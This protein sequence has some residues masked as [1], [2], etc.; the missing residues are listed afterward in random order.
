[1]CRI[2]NDKIPSEIVITGS[3][4]WGTITMWMWWDRWI[5]WWGGG[6]CG[7]EQRWGGWKVETDEDDGGCGMDICWK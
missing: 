3:N 1:M 6:G 2:K 4:D 7:W 5:W